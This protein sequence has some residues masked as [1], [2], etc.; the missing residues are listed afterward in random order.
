M[1]DFGLSHTVCLFKKIFF[2]R[3]F[4]KVFLLICILFIYLNLLA[5]LCG[6]WDLSALTRDRIHTPGL[7]AESLIY[8]TTRVLPR[9]QL[10]LTENL[11]LVHSEFMAPSMT[12]IPL[13]QHPFSQTIIYPGEKV[14]LE[15][16][17]KW[18]NDQWFLGKGKTIRSAQLKRVVVPAILQ[19]IRAVLCSDSQSCLTLCDPMDC[20]PEG[21]SVHEFSQQEY[22][23][24]LPCPPPGHLPNPG[25]EPER[26][27][28]CQEDFL[29]L[30]PRKKP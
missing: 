1:I 11:M 6:M 22:W 21:P 10:L 5:T 7:E 25:I 24:E 16:E 2:Y 27:L 23:N 17:C 18:G 30:V 4:E 8:W 19:N 26:F 29:P 15:N 12:P 20:S 9:T 13:S 28:H 14:I 3:V